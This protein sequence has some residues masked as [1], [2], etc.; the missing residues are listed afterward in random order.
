MFSILRFVEKQTVEF[1]I[2]ARVNFRKAVRAR[3]G[4]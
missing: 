1:N 4:K 3:M 2:Q